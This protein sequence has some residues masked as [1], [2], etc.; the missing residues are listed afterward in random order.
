MAEQY[1]YDEVSKILGITP[2]QSNA[3][4]TVQSATTT[5]DTRGVDPQS[6]PTT[7]R[8]TFVQRNKRPGIDL[9][10]EPP[11]GFEGE[12]A[13]GQK[14]D[15]E[16]L[17]YARQMVGTRLR[18]N[19]EDQQKYLE[20]IFGPGN[21]R[22]SDNRRPIVTVF[23]PAKG[24]PI[25][26][27]FLGEKTTPVDVFSSAVATAP[28]AAGAMAGAALGQ[29]LP[30]RFLKFVGQ[31]ALGALGQETAAALRESFVSDDPL[32]QIVKE[33]ASDVPAT[34]AIDLALTGGAKVAG[35]LVKR[36]AGTS[37]SSELREGFSEA[38]DFFKKEMGVDYPTS[39]AEE[40]GW[41]LLGRAETAMSRN[42]GSSSAFERLQ[43]DKLNSFRQITQKLMASEL[44]PTK[45]GML[46]KLAEDVGQEAIDFLK[47][48]LSPV[49]EATFAARNKAAS[50]VNRVIM[51]EIGTATTQARELYP[52]KVGQSV[53][54]AV[55]RE[56][57]RFSTEAK[58]L[59]DQARSLGGTDKV[60]DLSG[61]ASKADALKRE[62]ASIVRKTNTPTPTLGPTGQPVL[63]TTQ[64]TELV[65][66]F[67]PDKVISTLDEISSWKGA[68]ASL[69]D[70][71]KVR[72]SIS[73][74]IEAGQALPGIET[75]YLNKVRSE[76]T[77]TIQ[78]ELGK[79]P[80][81]QLKAAWEQANTFYREGAP[82]FKGAK[83]FERKEIARLFRDIDSG[84][85]VADEAI[86]RNIGPTQYNA[87]KEFLGPNSPEFT[88]IKRAIADRLLPPMGDD[89]VV[90][91]QFLDGLE[92]LVKDKRAIAEDIFGADGVK[93]LRSLATTMEALQKSGSADL[94]DRAELQKLI[95]SSP[96]SVSRELTAMAARQR[97]L[98]KAYKSQ[99]LSDISSGKLGDTFNSTE[100]VNRMYSDASPGEVKKV[101]GLLK[102][103]PEK[104][105]EL[106][107]KVTER[108]LYEAQTGA[109]VTE[110]TSITQGTEARRSS[111]KALENIFGDGDNKA[112]MVELLG[113]DKVKGLENLAKLLRSGESAETAFK[114]ASSFAASEQINKAIS[115]GFLGYASHYIPQWIGSAIY[116][117]DW[118][119]KSVSAGIRGG[120]AG[121]E[122]LRSIIDLASDKGIS[123]PA[124]MR[125]I[126][127][128]EPFNE[129]ISQDFGSQ[130]NDVRSAIY[131]SFERFVTYGTPQ[132]KALQQQQWVDEVINR[133]KAEQESKSR[134]MTNQVQLPQRN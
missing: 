2:S 119:K 103:A 8:G 33:Q 102:D 107:R 92:T 93:R 110:P 134:G 99:I 40:T 19:P 1:S 76:I 21:V 27:S 51:D 35:G 97:D 128:S 42:P 26:F 111:V 101:V 64:A 54:E 60:L 17:R 44:D 120:Q 4:N 121:R 55:F 80:G 106:R 116:S 109:R 34:A 47:S 67:I 29:K 59:Y 71:V 56:K 85:F 46:N 130:A 100:F 117:M 12:D 90:G 18:E 32:S 118:L 115:G 112:K 23:D 7:Q 84:A 65:R 53:R 28:E 72:N 48:K 43:K 77:D 20:T 126:I 125:A 131:D 83:D 10:E 82:G 11:V 75:K 63:L 68:K 38:R 79:I 6:F 52:E 9:L 98:T 50:E 91:S 69:D 94:L 22:M 30:G 5:L 15:V 37:P 88:R 105:D 81:G 127:T 133:A 114:G 124:L 49:Q 70:L 14:S 45:V 25:E 39:L 24:Q 132:K 13:S 129:M 3:V 41:S 66:E 58:R 104:L 122:G 78:T 36:L 74:L 16:A 89:L 123:E 61:L 73:D 31:S 108:I 87:F 95:T 62:Q 96:A 113:P 86:V 57:D